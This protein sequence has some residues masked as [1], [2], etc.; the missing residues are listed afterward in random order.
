M[1]KVTK[2][3]VSAL[4]GS[5]AAVAS[6]QA[7]SKSVS[8]GAT[9]TYS[10]T[11]G[12]VTG[13]PIGMNSGVTFSGSGELDN[14]TT[15]TLTITGA[16]QAGYSSGSIAMTTPNMGGIKIN[17]ASG[18]TGIDRYDDMMPTAWEETNGTSLTT[19][20]QTVNG[21]GSKMNIEWTASADLLPEGAHFGIAFAPGAA[22]GTAVNDK[23]VSGDSA[24]VG[25][26]YDITAGTTGLVDGLNV[27]AGMSTIEQGV[28]TGSGFDADRTQY[29]AGATYAVGSVTV[30]YQYSRDNLQLAN[31]AS[32]SYY[33]NDAFGVSFA[34][35]DDLSISYGQHTSERNMTSASSVELE[36]QS[37]QMSY[38]MG[39]MSIKF[40][41]SQVD[42]ASYTSGSSA[43]WDGRTI[44]LTLAF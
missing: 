42:N 30:G 27:F 39:G 38:T 10:S 25:S 20:L 34:V 37:L 5:L 8:G 22:V 6:A 44:A 24:G 36:A 4:C 1:N 35:N 17:G 18:G 19:G 40:A 33:E 12:K 43:D 32:T 29:V 26:G 11:E 14:G 23:N 2:I 41:E 3:G 31:D 21:V 7:G 28:H 15:F 13:N 16:D 9:A